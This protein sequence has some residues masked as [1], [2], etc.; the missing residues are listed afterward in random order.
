VGVGAGGNEGPGKSLRGSA[1]NTVRKRELDLGVLF[2][3]KE[4]VRN[5]EDHKEENKSEYYHELL[6]AGTTNVILALDLSE[7]D[8]LDR[9]EAGPV[10]GGHVLVEGGD[11]VGAGELTELLV[12]VVGSAA[13][14]VPEPHTIVLDGE[15]LLLVDD[16]GG[17]DL[18]VHLLQVPQPLHEVP[19]PA[20][21]HKVVGGE[22]THA[23]DLGQGLLL[24]GAATAHNEVLLEL[25][26]NKKFFLNFIKF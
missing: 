21:G 4:T 23:V 12:H 6:G 3:G 9:A 7:S 25:D 22:K 5:I 8:D 2:F 18:T 16:A 11:G 20:L 17:K 19:E 14:V 1:G 10:A 15:G 24:S 13:R 26:N